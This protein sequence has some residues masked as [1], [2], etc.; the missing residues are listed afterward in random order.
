MASDQFRHLPLVWRRHKVKAGLHCA[1]EAQ[2]KAETRACSILAPC[3]KP[4]FH[5]TAGNDLL[6]LMTISPVATRLAH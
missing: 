4:P 6:N 2:N 1:D 3:K 5:D